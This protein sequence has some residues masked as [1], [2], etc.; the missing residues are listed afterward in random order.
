MQNKI[1]IFIYCLLK[2]YFILIFIT[3][4]NNVLKFN[5]KIKY[6]IF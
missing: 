1:I 5:L 2:I 4:E 6:N 3:I